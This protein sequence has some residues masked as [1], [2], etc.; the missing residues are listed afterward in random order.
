M[1]WRRA[2]TVFHAARP[3]SN[4][5]PAEC[6]TTFDKLLWTPDLSVLLYLLARHSLREST[7][8][9]PTSIATLRSSTHLQPCELVSNP[10]GTLRFLWPFCSCAS[11]RIV[12]MCHISYSPP[13]PPPNR[14][15]HIG[16]PPQ[17]KPTQLADD[18]LL[19]TF[20]HLHLVVTMLAP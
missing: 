16:V 18:N 10:C 5:P 2:I 8:F 4:D 15:L 1:P 17:N 12:A 6:C 20:L 11:Q 3:S 19:R 14:F 9:S 13:P 7:T